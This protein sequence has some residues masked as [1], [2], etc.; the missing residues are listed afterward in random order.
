MYESF[1]TQSAGLKAF[2]ESRLVLTFLPILEVTGVLSSF[3]LVKEGKAGK[4]T[5]WSL[6]LKNFPSK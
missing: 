2:K 5:P 6:I 1:G 3:R 4:G